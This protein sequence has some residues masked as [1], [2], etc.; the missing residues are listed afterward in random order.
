MEKLYDVAIIGTGIAGTVLAAIL[1]KNNVNV[2]M[3]EAGIHPRFSVGESMVSET[4]IFAKILA[5]RYNIPELAYI[6]S[7]EDL[8]KNVG[9]S[10][11]GIKLNFAYAWHGANQAHD[12]HQIT[13]TPLLGA[14]SHL[15]RQDIDAYFL[16]LAVSFGADLKQ[17]IKIKDFDISDHGVVLMTDG[18]TII[19]SKY[20]VD[21]SG[22]RS[23]VADKFNLRTTPNPM[24]T[25]SR[26]LFTHMVD[27]AHYE[28]AIYPQSVHRAPT[29]LCQGTLH[30]IFK[31]GWLWVI[32]FNNHPY[33][34]NPLCSIGLQLDT[35]I[36][37]LPKDPETEFSE[38]LLSYPD[39][40]KQFTHAKRVREWTVAHRLSYTSDRAVGNRYCLLAHAA[41]FVDPLFSR[42]LVNTFGSI[43][44]LAPKILQAIKTE[45]WSREAFL[46]VERYTLNFTKYN[47]RLVANSFTAFQNFE[48]WNAWYRIWVMLTL[49]GTICLGKIFSN[50]TM[51]RDDDELTRQIEYFFSNG[52]FTKESHEY[53]ELFD[54]ACSVMERVQANTISQNEAIDTLFCLFQKYEPYLPPVGLSNRKDRFNTRP[55]EETMNKV[56]QWLATTPE[57]FRTTYSRLPSVGRLNFLDD[58]RYG[59]RLEM[60]EA[61]KYCLSE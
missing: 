52:P 28:D 11:C 38:F 46:S 56:K 17:K 47:D 51:T 54:Q 41:G 16:H 29:Y 48:L 53:E 2:I 39:I 27:V 49:F 31:G 59:S 36:Y 44:L 26:S 23:I 30:H 58:Y 14:E 6:A 32:P 5:E 8:I 22:Y 13:S 25:H 1:A 45:N 3:I 60:A 50:F 7:P 55:V 43:N 33:S 40:A 15:F 20:L 35:R 61:S 18:D 4:A 19:R 42:G 24:Q 34:T 10:S 57:P 9:S 37:G 21:S 12:Y